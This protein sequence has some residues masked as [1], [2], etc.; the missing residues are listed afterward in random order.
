MKDVEVPQSWSQL[1]AAQ[2]RIRR[3]I[4]KALMA[5]L[6]VAAAV[7]VMTAQGRGR[8]APAL[9]DKVIMAGI[10]EVHRLLTSAQAVAAVVRA[11]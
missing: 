11:Q 8:A 2:T 5:V 9:R 7:P 6:A 10:Q 4:E 1:A 3:Q